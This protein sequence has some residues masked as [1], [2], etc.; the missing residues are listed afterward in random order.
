MDTQFRLL[1]GRGYT[2]ALIVVD[3]QVSVQVWTRLAAR[4]ESIREQQ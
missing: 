1:N 3:V 2:H 4:F